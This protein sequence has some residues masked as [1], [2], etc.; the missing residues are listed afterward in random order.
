MPSPASRSSDAAAS[1]L[2]LSRKI[3]NPASVRPRS[4]SC[5]TAPASGSARV[6]TA[7]TRLPAA[8]SASRIPWAA[9]GTP[10]DTASTDSGAP[11]VTRMRP[12]DGSSTNAEPIRRSWSNGTEAIVRTPAS[13]TRSDS[14]ASHS[15]TS[16]GLPPTARPSSMVASLQTRPRRRTES[17]APPDG[18]TA[19]TKLIAPSVRVP[20]LSVSSTSMSP[21]SSIQTSRLTRTPFRA[22][23][24]DPV[25]RL[26]VTTAGRS[27]GVIPTAMASENSSDSSSGRSRIRL[28]TKIEV[29]STPATWTSSTENFR[30]PVWNSV[31]SWRSPRPAAMRPNSARAPVSTTTARPPPPR[32]TV[33]MNA[34]DDISASSAPG[35]PGA[36][37]FSA[38]MDSPVSTDSSHSRASTSVNRTSAGTICPNVSCT[39]SPGTSSRTSIGREWPSRR[40]TTSCVICVCNACAASSARYSL[41]NP[42]PTETSRIRAMIAAFVRSPTKNETAAVT[43]RRR[44]NALRSWRASTDQGRTRCTVMTLSPSVSRR[45][46]ASSELSPSGPLPRR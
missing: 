37:D 1:S 10:T 32:T 2:G 26:V 29:V 45:S 23:R 9:S 28:I 36:A 34:H 40:T 22:R 41:T 24:R 25:A 6:A 44:S 13:D 27:C 11:F 8:N 35:G 20:V 14:A 5:V 17:A 31:T 43:T 15:A 16:S 46:R 3:R 39:T 42:S 30:R 33:P 19:R 7:T 4:S 21:R 38:G 12:A 18:S